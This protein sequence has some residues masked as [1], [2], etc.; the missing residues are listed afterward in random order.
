[1]ID[2][3]LLISAGVFAGKR[4]S[5]LTLRIADKYNLVLSSRIIDEL[6]EVMEI[7]FPNKKSCLER[8]LARLS[9]EIAYTPLEIDDD[10]Y[11]KIRDKKDYP[12]LASAIIADVDVFITGDKDFGGLDLERPEIMTIRD[13]DKKYL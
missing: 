6:R 13:F 4:T 3:N 11:P 10:I 8:F 9:Y 12:I 2:T 5:T 1:M 7:K